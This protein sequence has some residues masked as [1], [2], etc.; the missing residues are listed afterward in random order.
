MSA[1]I[2]AIVRHLMT[3]LGAAWAGSDAEVGK[4]LRELVE[5]IA[6]GDTNAIGGAIVMLAAIMWSIYDK[7][8]KAIVRK[9]D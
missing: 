1:M 6:S 9:A 5:Q 8:R 4:I 2:A 3:L 7:R